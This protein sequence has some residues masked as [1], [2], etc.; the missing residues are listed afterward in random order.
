MIPGVLEYIGCFHGDTLAGFSENY[1]QDNA[2]WLVS[3]RY[4]PAFLNKYLSYGL[5]DGILN[6]YLNGKKMDYVLDGWR[7]IHHRTEFQDHLMRVFGFV[8]E[9]AVIKIVYSAK[10]RMVVN[11]AYPFRNAV[12]FFC[13]RWVNSFMDNARAVLRQED[14]RRACKKQKTRSCQ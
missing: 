6:H 4:D 10:F 12:W 7:S 3:I 2:V 1:I 14:I 11:M 13:D 8:K 9:Y 5:I